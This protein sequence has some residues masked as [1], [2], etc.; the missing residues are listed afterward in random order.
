M[1]KN[2]MKKTISLILALAV[3]ASFALPAGA[4][5]PRIGTVSLNQARTTITLN[6]AESVKLND[7]VD[8]ASQIT[9][10]KD[11]SP[12]TALPYGSTATC[13]SATIKINL[14]SALNSKSTYVT[15]AS[16]T[17]VGQTTNMVSPSFDAKGPGAI[18]SVAIDGTKKV[19]TIKLDGAI[20]SA[21][22]TTTLYDGDIYL[23]RDGSNF[24]EEIKQNQITFD[25]ASGTIKITL[26]SA[27]TGEK[28]RFKISAGTIAYAN[29]GNINLEDLITPAISAARILPKFDPNKDFKME[30]DFSTITMT[31]DKN[32]Y[33]AS[34]EIE[35]RIDENV[36]ISLN[37]GNFLPLNISDKVTI[38]GNVLTIKLR[39]PVDSDYNRIK[40]R[41]NVLMGEN[42]DVIDTEILSPMFGISDV[43]RD[44]PMYKSISY[45]KAKKQVSIKYNA[46][47]YPVSVSNLKAMIQVSRNKG[48]FKDLSAY[49][50]AEIYGKDTILITLDQGLSG[51]GNRFRIQPNA[52]KG[53]NNNVQT[54]LQ[55]TGYVDTTAES[56]EEFEADF[57]ISED[58]K[59]VDI[60]FDRYIQSAYPLDTDLE[61]LKDDISIMRNAGYNDL[62]E[63]DYISING[64][65]LR[66]VFQRALSTTDVI[67]ISKFALKDSYGAIMS[68]DIKV[69]PS[70]S[71]S[72]DILDLDDGVTISAD[73]KTVTISF[74]ERVYNN[75]SSTASLKQ[76]IRVAYNGVDFEELDDEVKFEFEG[77]GMISITFPQTISNPEARIKIL[78]GALQNSKGE[79]ITEEIVTNPLGR[80]SEN[81]K[82]SIGTKRVYIGTEDE[83]TD[84]SGNR[85]I[86]MEISMTKAS[87]VI[88]TM[89]YG[90]TL[91]VEFP[92]YAYSTV[93]DINCATLKQLIEKNATITVI[94]AGVTQSFK[95]DELQLDDALANLGIEDA[96]AQ[97][98][99]IEIGTARVGTPYLT[100]FEAKAEMKDFDI[101]VPAT[102]LSILYV[103]VNKNYAVTKY[104]EYVEKRFSIKAKDAQEKNVTVVR[105]EGSGKV[106]PVPTVRKSSTGG[107][108]LSAKVKNNGVYGVIKANRSFT[109]T[110]AWAEEA[111]N[112]LASRMILQNASNGPCRAQD[113]VSR[114]EVA[115]MITR[116][117]GLLTDKSGT[118]SFFDVVPTD[119][120]FSSTSIAVENDLIRGYG[121][122]TFGPERNIT[123]QEVMTIMARVMEYLGSTENKDMTMDE[124]EDIL[125]RFKDAGKVADWAKINMAKCVAADVVRGD[126]KGYLNPNASLTRAEMSQLIYNLMVNYGLLG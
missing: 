47:I 27:L 29:S 88:G 54:I 124:A 9:I 117:L 84:L 77:M 122:G 42:G 70:L 98:V 33:F 11:S 21:L 39:Y 3:M 76:M 109:D 43:Q 4:Y 82:V 95:A 121:D 96:L 38:S 86:E 36:L 81:T 73:K 78:P 125:A 52:I 72:K 67:R 74:T 101:V 40:I 83:S 75:M 23:A 57:N 66:I 30:S 85:S 6:L 94:A 15:I 16:G 10:T 97:N 48:G 46:T 12:A 28:S 45:D 31:F 61:Y 25:G 44:A 115:E 120:Y 50:T 34:D 49:D 17:F 58:M 103:G 65:T 91:S 68:N 64:R 119:W 26:S 123:R 5:A 62:N 89:S 110:P 8:L 69:G 41:E 32:I 99:S 104:P 22:G 24:Y 56:Y 71:G 13:D 112:T 51:D 14:T 93:L 63:G 107:Y 1:K 111:V 105:I 59:T 37:S 102:E 60:N 79:T 53:E 2:F 35:K 19:V 113:A 126:D 80:S 106:N 87:S 108:Y 92:E 7:G 18:S 55:V 114:A 20:T 100:N 90:E 116:T 118:S